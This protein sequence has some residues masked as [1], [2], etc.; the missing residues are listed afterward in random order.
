VIAHYQLLGA[1]GCPVCR[2]IPK[3]PQ[4]GAV[5]RFRSQRAASSLW[6]GAGFEVGARYQVVTVER[7]FGD[8]IKGEAIVRLAP[9]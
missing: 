9:S 5:V 7:L 1:V 8:A 6:P 2:E 3:A 4:V